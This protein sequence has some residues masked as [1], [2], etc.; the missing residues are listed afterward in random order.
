MNE[1]IYIVRFKRLKVLFVLAAVGGLLALL[2]IT[3]FRK[4][5]QNPFLYGLIFIVPFYFYVHY[6]AFV[7]WK[8]RYKGLNSNEWAIAFVLTASNIGFILIALYCL[9][10]IIPD[11]RRKGRYE[12]AL[13]L[14]S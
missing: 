2:G 13:D 3:L 7:H 9:H 10:N 1:E 5:G 8:E 4:M 14:K 12:R 11:M 6:L